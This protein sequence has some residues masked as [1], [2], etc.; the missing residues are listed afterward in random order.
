L[1]IIAVLRLQNKDKTP[2]KAR[3]KRSFNEKITLLLPFVWDLNFEGFIFSDILA[4]T[5]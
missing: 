2:E 5:C 3:I 1:R 4:L